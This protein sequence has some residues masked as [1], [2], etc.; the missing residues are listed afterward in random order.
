MKKWSKR[1][2]VVFVVSVLVW[3]AYVAW[4]QPPILQ[5]IV[6]YG[7][8][9]KEGK[10]LDVYY[11]KNRLSEKSPVVFFVH[12][13]A[14]VVGRKEAINMN[15]FNGAIATLRDSGFTIISPEYTLAGVNQKAFPN[16]IDD[17]IDAINYCVDHAEELEIDTNRMGVF[18]ESAGA[19]IALMIGYGMENDSFPR[20][21]P[22]DYVVDVYGPTQLEGVYKN[23]LVDSIEV[24]VDK[25]P[26][27]LQGK[28]D[29]TRQIIGFNP[30]EDTLRS[31]RIMDFY[32]PLLYVNR[33][34]PPTLIIQGNQDLIVPPSQSYMLDSALAHHGVFHKV[35]YLKGVNHA[36]FG[37]TSEQKSKIQ[38]V[39][40]Q[41]ILS[42][43]KNED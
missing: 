3:M 26:K 39:L 15:R 28:V 34:S 30:L 24:W 13:G 29:I 2:A 1:I 38:E 40:S 5:G 21:K 23:P 37:A 43:Y 25:L 6:A 27:S 8:S 32:S 33:D 41:F 16:C 31:Q 9:Y 18:G 36:F 10:S 42:Q 19:H 22:M 35:L 11:P 7:I 20:C 12:G 17:V 14:W 4:L